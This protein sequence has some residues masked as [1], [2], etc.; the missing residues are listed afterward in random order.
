MDTGGDEEEE[1]EEER[2]AHKSVISVARGH[3]N[4]KICQVD[5]CVCG[6]AIF[7]FL[8]FLLACRTQNSSN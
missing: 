4:V 8:C 7:S 6:S 5:A 2:K 3:E 1:E